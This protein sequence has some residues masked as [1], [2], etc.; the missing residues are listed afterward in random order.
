M[1][2]FIAVLLFSVTAFAAKK[3]VSFKCYADHLSILGRVNAA[4]P[5]AVV[6]AATVVRGNHQEEVELSGSLLKGKK[7]LTLKL[8]SSSIDAE[9]MSINAVLNK[10]KKSTYVYADSIVD[11][12]FMT[13]HKLKH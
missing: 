13:C 8:T 11:T 4:N 12:L 9:T 10:S 2:L 5:N 6:G 1:K 3:T 7:A